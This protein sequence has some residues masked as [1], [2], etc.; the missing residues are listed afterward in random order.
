MLSQRDKEG[1]FLLDHRG[2]MGLPDETVRQSGLPPGSGRG[3]FETS[4]Y[5]CSHCEAVVVQNPDRKRERA[6]CRGCDHMIC[7]PCAAIKAQT[8]K[9]KTFK[10]V[11][12]ELMAQAAQQ[13]NGP[14]VLL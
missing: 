8:L 14:L 4:T 1:Y 11:V 5:T 6:Y 7:D 13:A 3:L 12:D 9:C 10:Q 2:S